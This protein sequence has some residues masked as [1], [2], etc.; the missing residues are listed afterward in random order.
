M[1]SNVF[2]KFPSVEWKGSVKLDCCGNETK[3]MRVFYLQM[4][5]FFS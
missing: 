1:V 2:A 3:K 5:V 4:F